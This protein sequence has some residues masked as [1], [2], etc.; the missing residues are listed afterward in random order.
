MFI[1]LKK[2]YNSVPHAAIWKAP[3]KLGASE[4]IIIELI[5]SFYSDM[6]AQVQLVKPPIVDPLR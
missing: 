6:Q 5:R 1:D 4:S 3:G 2:V